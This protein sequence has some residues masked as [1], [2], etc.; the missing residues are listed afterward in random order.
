[1]PSELQGHWQ[2]AGRP[3]LDLDLDLGE[4]LLLPGEPIFGLELP[5]LRWR[6]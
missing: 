3:D 5:Q 4:G 1:M 2:P 6:P